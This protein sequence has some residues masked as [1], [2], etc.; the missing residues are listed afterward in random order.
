MFGYKTGI[1]LVET[2]VL[3]LP[4]MMCTQ[5]NVKFIEWLQ[6]KFYKTRTPQI[7]IFSQRTRLQ[8]LNLY[9]KIRFVL[10]F[11]SQPPLML[12]LSIKHLALF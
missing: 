3:G 2:H 1:E 8:S 9:Y 12:L 4:T 5:E 6:R 7:T 11:I 10:Q